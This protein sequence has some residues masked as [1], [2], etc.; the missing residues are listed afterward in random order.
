MKEEEEEKPGIDARSDLLGRR[1]TALRIWLDV[2]VGVKK[3]DSE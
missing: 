2:G 3:M 1:V